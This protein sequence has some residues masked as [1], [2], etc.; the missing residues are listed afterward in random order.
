M[1]NRILLKGC[2]PEPLASYLKALALFRLVAEQRDPAVRGWWENDLFHLKSELDEDSLVKFFLEDY[3]PTPIVAPWNGGSGFYEGDDIVGREAIRSSVSEQFKVYRETIET[4]LSWPE[5]P[6]TSELSL[7]ALIERVEAAAANLKGKKRDSLLEVV[8][9]T[10]E[11]VTAAIDWFTSKAALEYSIKELDQQTAV[12]KKAGDEEKKKS[13]AIKELLRPAKKLRTIVKQLS[14]A[15]GK[16]ELVRASRNRLNDR[17]VD[18]IDAAVA[19]LA[20]DNL[21]YPPLVG[22]AGSEGRLDYTNA[23]MSHLSSLLLSPENADRS[24]R[25]LRHSLFR[26]ATDGLERSS[27]G[28]HDPGRAGGYNQGYGIEL[29]NFPMN[30]WDFVLTMEGTVA[31]ASGVSRRQGNTSRIASSSPFTVHARAVGY[32]SSADNDEKEARKEVWMP[33]W[34]R[35]VQYEELRAVLREGRADIGR[36]PATNGIEFAEAVASLGV[37]RGIT[38]FVRYSLL[39]RRGKSF[40]AFPSG[41]FSVEARSESDLVRNL[42]PLLDRV[43]HFLRSFTK[44]DPP[45]RFTSYR[46]EIDEAIYQLLLRGSSA[47]AKRLM[48]AIGRMEQLFA[49]RDQSKEP[50]LYAPLYGLDPKWLLAADDG[51]LEVRL[52]AALASIGPTDKVGSIRANLSSIDPGKP[53]SW[54]DGKGQ[55]HWSGNSLALR[56]ANLFQHRMMDAERL[57]CRSNPT[58]GSVKLR[59]EDAAAFIEGNLDETLIEDLL[60][61]FALIRWDNREAVRQVADEL[62]VRWS[63]PVANQVIPRSWALL[64]HLYWPGPFIESNGKEIKVSPEPSIIPLLCA[65]RIG[66]A[67]EIGARRLFIAGLTP[68]R[69]RLPDHQAVTDRRRTSFPVAQST[70]TLEACNP[71]ER[72]TTMNS[73]VNPITKGKSPMEELMFENL[74][75]VPRLLLEAELKPVQGDRFQPT[76]FADLGAAV[77][78]RPDGK[79]MLLVES[80]QSIANRLEHTCLNGDGAHIAK[81]SKVCHTS[82][83]N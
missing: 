14:R 36:K 22:V 61:G 75:N 55:A 50:K 83:P 77:Y 60:F 73:I 67:C 48:A 7:G 70:L 64:K 20:D 30:P 26:E 52:A 40:I 49:E 63:K 15:A 69:A 6:S 46:R 58:W 10:Q 9:K 80:A 66:D 31:W 17:A 56:L 44:H 21:A 33:L 3:C 81:D 23:F 16:G 19:V 32:A 59:A 71:L 82:S 29:K 76:G 13:R 38:D 37:D 78:E 79:R 54:H 25:L 5:L 62:F 51:S 72:R 39:K 2:T 24:R 45:A 12:S 74:V 65:N 53:R 57:Q 11:K 8:A 47:Y 68:M 27:V 34:N 18:W 1:T 4:I 35:P 41:R 43:D 42:H 28:Q